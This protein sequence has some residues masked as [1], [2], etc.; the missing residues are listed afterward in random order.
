M[1]RAALQM[2]RNAAAA[3]WGASET[4]QQPRCRNVLP[5]NACV[6]SVVGAG[7]LRFAMALPLHLRMPVHVPGVRTAAIPAIAEQQSREFICTAAG[8]IMCVR[9]QMQ[10][11][12]AVRTAKYQAHIAA[13]ICSCISFNYA[14]IP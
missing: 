8:F 12:A 6:M 9:N 13:G 4:Q 2:S 10:M 7:A 11:P 5:S 3:S 1:H 14:C